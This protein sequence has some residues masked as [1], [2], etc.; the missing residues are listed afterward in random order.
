MAARLV[1]ARVAVMALIA[2]ATSCADFPDSRFHQD[3]SPEP[4]GAATDGPAVDSS[5]PGRDGAVDSDGPGRDAPPS[6]DGPG[7]DGP[8]PDGPGADAASDVGVT[9]DG[10][11]D[12]AL[13]KPSSFVSCKSTK[14]MLKCN[15]AGDGTVVVNCGTASCSASLMRC[16]ECDPKT[17]TKT[18][19]GSSV[20][21]CT[22]DGLFKTTSCAKGCQNGV[23]CQDADL[24]GVTTCAGDCN[25]ND[26]SVK[27]SQTS[28]FD[29]A[30]NGSFDY[31]C[32][33]KVEREYSGTSSCRFSAGSCIGDGWTSAVPDCGKS[34]SFD[35]C[36][37]AGPNCKA[38]LVTRTQRCR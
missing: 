13:C 32:D 23:C 15:T 7:A 31:N 12:G 17:S 4:D 27:P 21:S 34:G 3:G 25:D 14:E 20:R 36:R 2:F 29:K 1:V 30:S 26:F 19:S 5:Q 22:S 37:Q 18:C 16:D 11:P 38:N 8:T 28:F 6:I 35:D 33:K 9:T 10:V 24:D